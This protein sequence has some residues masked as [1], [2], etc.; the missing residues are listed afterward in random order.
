VEAGTTGLEVI[1]ANQST[2]GTFGLTFTNNDEPIGA[3]RLRFFLTNAI[4]KIE[5]IV[6][7]RCTRIGDHSDVTRGGDKDVLHNWDTVR[8]R[9]GGEFYDLRVS[10][11]NAIRIAFRRFVP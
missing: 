10:S 11:S 7:Q 1:A 8:L 5:S 2:A 9:L 6:D 3:T 4:F